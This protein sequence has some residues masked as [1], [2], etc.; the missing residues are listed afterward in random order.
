MVNGLEKERNVEYLDGL[1]VY[2]S[3]TDFVNDWE[4]MVYLDRGG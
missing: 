4:V 3:I 1:A 2:C